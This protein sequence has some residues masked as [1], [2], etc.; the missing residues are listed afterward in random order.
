MHPFYLLRAIHYL[1]TDLNY[2]Y[3]INNF[4]LEYRFILSLL[5]L[6]TTPLERWKKNYNF[7]KNSEGVVLKKK[8]SF[9]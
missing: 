5:A 3:N 2:N 9:L 1:S 8:D 4:S 7:D 6:K